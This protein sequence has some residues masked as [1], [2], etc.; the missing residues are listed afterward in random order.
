MAALMIV[1]LTN[2]KGGVGKSTLAV[3]LAVEWSLRGRRVLVLDADPQGTALAWSELRAAE[4]LAGPTV[5]GVG[6]NVR[7]VLLEVAG[8]WDVVLVDTAGRQSKRVIAALRESDLVLMPCT[9][10][11]PDVWAL[12]ETIEVVREVQAIRS[13]LRAAV[14][15]NGTT[16][17]KLSNTARE[18]VGQMGVDVAASI[19]R[20]TAIA[21][22][23]TAGQSV[24]EREPKGAGASEIRALADAAEALVLGATRVA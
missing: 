20:R 6:D 11:G 2:S 19:A 18:A 24:V 9:P 1:T 5:L 23:I 17:T 13:E 3:S 21:E 7:T 22:A 10:A 16:A 8:D 14:V 15:V 4:G 12:S